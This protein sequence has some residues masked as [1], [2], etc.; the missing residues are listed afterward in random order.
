VFS[1]VVTDAFTGCKTELCRVGSNPE[2]IAEGARN[3]NIQIGRRWRR[4]YCT[5]GIV[6]LSEE[7]PGT[8]PRT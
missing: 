8:E 4:R 2:A 1:I 5:V 3:K 6:N 7:A